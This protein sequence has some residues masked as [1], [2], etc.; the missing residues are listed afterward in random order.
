MVGQKYLVRQLL[1][2]ARKTI[3][4]CYEFE[5]EATELLGRAEE[6]FLSISEKQRQESID[7]R[8]CIEAANGT[9]AEIL[10]HRKELN[11]G[12]STGFA[13][14]DQKLLALKRK[15]LVILAARPSMG[16]TS[17]AMNIAE[18]VAIK[19]DGT[20]GVPVAV[21]SL[22]M[23]AEALAMR[24]LC[25]RGGVSFHTISSERGRFVAAPQKVQLQQAAA[26]LGR[27]P[28]Y[29]DDTAGLEISELRSRARRLKKRHGVKLVVVDYL[30][31]MHCSSC[32]KE[33]RQRET[34]AISSGL[35]AMAKELD[36]PVI[37]LSQLSR[38]PE[39]RGDKSAKPRLSDLRDSG[40][41]EQDA[42]V[43][44]LLRR[45]TKYKEDEKSDD[46]R[47]AIVDIAKNRNGPTGEVELNFDASIT[48]FYDRMPDFRSE[49]A[50]G[51]VVQ[52]ELSG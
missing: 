7:W 1:D 19:K 40:A 23:S 51:P 9:I 44:M 28:L 12:L 2:Q 32:A 13:D 14:I 42:D 37:V 52:G 35:K 21:F 50:S 15:E 41:I 5:G 22:E 33:G 4:D 3:E 49:D 6:A 31:L 46:E 16:K 10:D 18:N 43:V 20:A 36:V 27:A 17:L 48:R 45:P 25:S 38:N 24:M 39:M 8:K 26:I 30:Q 11:L 29:V 47:L 34:S